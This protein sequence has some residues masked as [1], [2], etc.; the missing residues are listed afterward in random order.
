MEEGVLRTIRIPSNLLCLSDKLFEANYENPFK[1]RKLEFNKN[2][3][4]NKGNTFHNSNLPVINWRNKIKNNENIND[5][6]NE[7]EKA[8]RETEIK[9]KKNKNKE[10]LNKIKNRQLK[11]ELFNKAY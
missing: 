7:E 6:N 9:Y 10:N 1:Q 5:N 8:H 4:N 11:I 3:I 2:K